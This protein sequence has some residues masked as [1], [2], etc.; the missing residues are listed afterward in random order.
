MEVTTIAI[1]V[2]VKVTSI[3]F[4]FPSLHTMPNHF[5]VD[6]LP[7][8]ASQPPE[9]DH[10]NDAL[11]HAPERRR[12]DIIVVRPFS[13]IPKQAAMPR[14]SPRPP[15]QD[16]SRTLARNIKNTENTS[17]S[18]STLIRTHLRRHRRLPLPRWGPPVGPVPHL[19]PLPARRRAETA[20]A[21]TSPPSPGHVNHARACAASPAPTPPSLPLAPAPEMAGIRKSNPA[22]LSSPTPHVGRRFPPLP[23]TSGSPPGCAVAAVGFA[24]PRS[25]PSTPPPSRFV[26]GALIPSRTAAFASPFAPSPSP[27]AAVLRRCRNRAAPSRA[28]AAGPARVGVMERGGPCDGLCRFRIHLGTRGDC[29]LPA[30]DGG[31]T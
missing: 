4:A 1:S 16:A 12:F 19:P 20:A 29:P 25:T 26:A 5:F 10:A 17:F 8:C 21:P 2:C 9:H 13:S 31:E 30:G 24:W 11:E 14:I 27:P 3:S 18:S 7:F 22:S 23:A 6:H 15:L 28:M